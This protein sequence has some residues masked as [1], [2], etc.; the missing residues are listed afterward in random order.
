METAE[1]DDLRLVD[2]LREGAEG[3]YEEWIKRFQQRVYA[4]ALR[5]LNDQGEACDVVQEVFLKVFRNIGNFRGQSSLKTWMYRITVNEPY[6]ARRW[7]S[8]HRRG[9]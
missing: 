2:N 1:A 4:L 7:F 3:A 5:L 8:R 9:E 6:N